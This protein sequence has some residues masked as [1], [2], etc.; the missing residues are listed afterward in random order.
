MTAE[1]SVAQF[2]TLNYQLSVKVTLA[3]AVAA[4]YNRRLLR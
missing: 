3:F 1:I 4:V 2:S